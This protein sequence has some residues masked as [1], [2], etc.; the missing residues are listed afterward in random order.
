MASASPV[1]SAPSTIQKLLNAIVK[2][3]LFNPYL[4]T[5]KQVR[6]LLHLQPI[7]TAHPC[8]KRGGRQ[9]LLVKTDK[10]IVEINISTI[11]PINFINIA[12]VS[13]IEGNLAERMMLYLPYLG[14][15]KD[16]TIQMITSGQVIILPLSTTIFAI[17]DMS[18][19]P[20]YFDLVAYVFHP[21][22]SASVLTYG[23]RTNSSGIIHSGDIQP[24]L[25]QFLKNFEN[26]PEDTSVC[27]GVVGYNK[28]AL[29][30][31]VIQLPALCAV[32]PITGLIY[33]I[34]CPLDR[35]TIGESSCAIIAVLRKVR[36][37]IELCVLS[38]PITIDNINTG[39]IS[40]LTIRLVRHSII[41]ANHIFNSPSQVSQVACELSIDSS[42]IQIEEEVSSKEH[43]TVITFITN[44]LD[45]KIVA[46]IHRIG[47]TIFTGNGLSDRQISQEQTPIMPCAFGNLKDEPACA[48]CYL[49]ESS[50]SK[51]ELN[52]AIAI[53]HSSGKI[54]D[55]LANASTNS[56]NCIMIIYSTNPNNSEILKQ[57][58]LGH[59]QPLITH[60]NNLCINAAC[61]VGPNGLILIDIN[62]RLFWYRG[63]RLSHFSGVDISVPTF[64]DEVSNIFTPENIEMW[65]ITITTNPVARLPY[66]LVVDKTDK[67]VCWKGKMYSFTLEELIK[68]IISMSYD[69][70]SANQHD[71]IDLL[72][73]LSVILE[74]SQIKI[75]RDSVCKALEDKKSADIEYLSKEYKI[76][77]NK[78]Y[79]NI[80]GIEK[81]YVDKLRQKLQTLKHQLN[82]LIQ[83]ITNTL[84]NFSSR[85][86]VSSNTQSL[87]RILRSSKISS[88]VE[89]AKSMSA[90]EKMALFEKICTH[91]GLILGNVDVD[92]Y[93]K[94]LSAIQNGSFHNLV[95]KLAIGGASGF[96]QNPRMPFLD[97]DTIS[98][99]LEITAKNNSHP[100]YSPSGIIL[101]QGSEGSEVIKS[102]IPVPILDFLTELKEPSKIDWFTTANE[103]QFAMWRILMRNV[104]SSCNASRSFNIPQSSNDIG[105]WIIHILLSLSENIVAGMSGLPN[106][107]TD[108]DNTTCQM[109][110]GLFGQV[111]ATMASTQNILCK[112]FMLIYKD[113]EKIEIIPTEQ[114]WVIVRMT[115]LLPYTCWD[116]TNWNKN[117]LLYIVRAIR[118]YITNGPAEKM[119]KMLTHTKK[120]QT[121]KSPIL[122][123]FIR[124]IVEILFYTAE[125]KIQLTPEI[126]TRLIKHKLL[127]EEITTGTK[128]LCD[129][130]NNLIKYF[131][132]I[133]KGESFQD[134]FK[135]IIKIALF[136]YI[137]HSQNIDGEKKSIK[138]CVKSCED[139]EEIISIYKST[140]TATTDGWKSSNSPEHSIHM[141]EILGFDI[142]SKDVA[143]ASGVSTYKPGYTGEGIASLKSAL[144][145]ISQESAIVPILTTVDILGEIQGSSDAVALI[146]SLPAITCANIL[147]I[148]DNNLGKLM[149]VAG[150]VDCDNTLRH[151]ID[152]LMLGWQDPIKAENTV[153]HEVFGMHTHI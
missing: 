5:E 35:A 46:R 116:T 105:F 140:I 135:E 24:S 44:D 59:K 152:I 131:E 79:N 113:I 42:S 63:V 33:T 101:P 122:L 2:K 80:D 48:I 57:N 12:L 139:I 83:P 103:E 66:P 148:P 18:K 27:I 21:N 4:T 41:D 115:K 149:E 147:A 107:E 9:M 73:Q 132:S 78:F 91:N 74:E 68:I 125:N 55:T 13:N 124:L 145:V 127:R 34:P 64:G 153:L 119:Q 100:L 97:A 110:R 7:G 146:K 121:I 40:E 14:T 112:A 3:Y 54:I 37:N 104:L 86:G 62:G 65:I 60:L 96:S 1:A 98:S 137:K 32:D 47:T 69:E 143:N 23:L 144:A 151:I 95:C 120:I 77:L 92:L 61:E 84:A 45:K 99:L 82:K 70:I 29:H 76:A 142:Y 75:F 136:C 19:G 67:T 36:G 28:T 109:M 58:D 52:N 129:H 31:F 85:K 123:A 20:T 26:L 16:N 49:N 43:S 117:L 10:G 38:K 17:S 90:D 53:Y 81:T 108:W 87:A 114:W 141:I 51:K 130:F 150:I 6:E 11:N 138:G 72:T 39:D 134:N 128:M 126:A 102:M 111:L 50:V 25:L 8:S 89:A 93:I 22:G 56:G 71:I 106:P 15:F 30:K 133:A 88:N 94:T 118:K